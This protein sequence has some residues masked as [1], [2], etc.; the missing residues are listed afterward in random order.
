MKKRLFY[1]APETELFVVRFEE[2]ILSGGGDSGNG[3]NAKFGDDGTV[4]NPTVHEY[5]DSF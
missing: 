3:S 2:N 5:E 4:Y 1:E